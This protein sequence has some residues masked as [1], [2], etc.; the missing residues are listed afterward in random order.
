MN[1]EL[2]NN[3]KEVKI[4]SIIEIPMHWNTIRL[5][6]LG[7]LING[8]SKG[9][10]YFGFGY[11]FVSY[12]N[13]YNDTI[14]VNSIST[15][16]NSNKEEQKFYS[17]KESD[18]FFTRTSET[19]DEIGFASTVIETLPNAIFSG[20][21]I[22]W[23]PKKR[24]LNKFYSKY[25]FRAHFNKNYLAG[26]INMVTRASL[27]QNVL[28]NLIVILPPPTEQTQ[29]ANYLDAKTQ[30]LDKK[31]N[32]L[33]TKIEYYKELRK[34]IINNTVT[35]GLDKNVKLKNSGI[36]WIGK[37]PAH[38]E[39]KRFK[40]VVKK[41][42]TGGT[43]STSN[44]SYFNGDNIWICISDI[45]DS[46][47]VSNSSIKLTD[48]AIKSANMI[49]SPKGSLLYSFKL[50][51]GKMAFVTEDVYTNEAV[52]S[53][54]PNK[55]IDLE[56]YYFMLPTFMFLQATENIYGAKMLNQKLISSAFI[57]HPPKKEQTEIATYLDAK[58]STID[59]IT[60]NL[61]TQIT[62][63]KELRKTLINDVVTGKVKVTA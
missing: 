8:I 49:R 29:I 13:V 61:Q 31:I 56:Y 19:L 47:F 60:T 35:K 55:K 42:T 18:V 26:E 39:V 24:L 21:V 4:G 25:L 27:N 41:Y 34:T 32:L 38:W 57:L 6:D 1:T 2:S 23:R 46:K 54:F 44:H 11:P 12:S 5:K 16:A 3:L 36:E 48:D 7:F 20:F 17:V 28:S 43:P 30:A 62:N 9:K 51:I 33:T 58:T 14:N 63:L 53:I 40:D 37:I 50:S 15:Y 52:L 22:R 59:K 10:E 45:G